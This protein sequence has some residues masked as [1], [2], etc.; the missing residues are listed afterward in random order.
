MRI[1]QFIFNK[2]VFLIARFRALIFSIFMVRVGK[3]TYFSRDVVILSPRSVKIGA[4]VKIN[5]GCRLDDNI[6]AGT[7]A[8]AIGV[9][10]L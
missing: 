5:V 2:Y 9:R 3:R 4:D 8:K 1:L 7:P 6:V 10:G